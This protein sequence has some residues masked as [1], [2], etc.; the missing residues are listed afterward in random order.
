[1]GE[2]SLAVTLRIGANIQNLQRIAEIKYHGMKMPLNE[3]ELI[4][5]FQINLSPQ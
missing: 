5:G 3:K 4:D 2:K 1:M